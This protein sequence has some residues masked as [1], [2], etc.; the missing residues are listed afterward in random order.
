MHDHSPQRKSELC[1]LAPPTAKKEHN[2]FLSLGSGTTYFQILLQFIQKAKKES[3]SRKIICCISR[4]LR[5]WPVAST[6]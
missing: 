3:Y 6:T 2:V 4:K 5:K 1:Y